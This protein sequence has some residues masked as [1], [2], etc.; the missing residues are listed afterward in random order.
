MSPMSK[1]PDM[2]WGHWPKFYIRTWSR[3]DGTYEL[4]LQLWTRLLHLLIVMEVAL[5]CPYTQLGASG[6]LVLGWV[7]TQIGIHSH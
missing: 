4:V 5:H 1:P 7:V 2:N 3:V 6:L